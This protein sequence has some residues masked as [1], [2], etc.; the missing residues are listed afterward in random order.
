MHSGLGQA[1]YSCVPLSPSSIIWH[2]GNL[3][4]WVYDCYLLADSQEK[5]IS[6][7]PN[8]RN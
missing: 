5:G 7:E 3:L 1:T 2:R 8:A 4:G 6:S